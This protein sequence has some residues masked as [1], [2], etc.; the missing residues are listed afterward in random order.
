MPA[1][2]R[3]RRWVKRLAISALAFVLILAAGAALLWAATPG[4]G[5]APARTAAILQAHGGT[6]DQGHPPSRVSAALIATEDSRFYSHHGLDPKGLLRGIRSLLTTGELQGATLD[7]QL[8]KLLYEDGRSTLGPEVSSGVLAFKL[9][10]KYSKTQ[11]LSMYLD[12]AYFGHDGYGVVKASEI[13]FGMAPDRLSWGQATLLAGLVNAPSAYDPT[14]H[15]TLARS[16]QQHVIARLVATGV[17]TKAQGAA[18]FAEPLHP[19]V[20]FGG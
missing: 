2:R 18:V 14:A 3:R 7:A 16:R 1:P 5:D 13:Y 6:S 9:D 15:L 17:F 8:A 20:P 11:I 4:V 19:A 10:E 12:A